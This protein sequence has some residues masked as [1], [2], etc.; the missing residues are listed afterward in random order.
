MDL[1]RV[2]RASTI[3]GGCLIFYLKSL[4]YLAY[5]ILSLDA[6]KAFDRVEWQYLFD[7]L[8]RFGVGVHFLRWVQ[9]LYSN[10]KAEVLT[11]GL[12][13]TPF[14]LNRRTRQGCHLSPLLFILA[15]E[16]LA[17]AIRKHADITGIKVG[18]IE[19]RISL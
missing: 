2:D 16:P 3:R 12:M 5:S 4:A 13:S 18:D 9:L 7:V 1:Y 10:P 19:H 15:I 8:Q 14:R 17:M 6:E 11:N